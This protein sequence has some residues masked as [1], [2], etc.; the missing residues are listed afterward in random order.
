MYEAY[1]SYQNIRR[2]QQ[3]AL[4]YSLM[5][6]PIQTY[7]TN[8]GLKCISKFIIYQMCAS[9]RTER[10]RRFLLLDSSAYSVSEVYTEEVFHEMERI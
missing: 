2:H 7:D 9:L 4:G 8:M 5:I 1:Q 3:C 10:N 6:Q